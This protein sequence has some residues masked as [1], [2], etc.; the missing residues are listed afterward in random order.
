MTDYENRL[1]LREFRVIPYEKSDRISTINL[2]HS[3]WGNDENIKRMRKRKII[4]LTPH[5]I[6][7]HILNKC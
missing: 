6:T 2:E 5:S 1:I 4:L 7:P 3:I